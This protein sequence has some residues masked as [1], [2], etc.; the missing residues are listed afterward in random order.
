MIFQVDRF[1][2]FD[3]QLDVTIKVGVAIRF[4]PHLYVFNSG[5]LI[6]M[7]KGIV[8]IVGRYTALF[9][10]I[11]N[12]VYLRLG[13]FIHVNCL[14][15]LQPPAERLGLDMKKG[16]EIVFR[17]ISLLKVLAY[18]S[19]RNTTTAPHRMRISMPVTGIGLYLRCRCYCRKPSS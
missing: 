3:F 6:R 5:I 10:K 17:H 19:K 7:E 12:S 16:V 1:S 15:V 4:I 14:C 11:L 8:V 18:P 13:F 2:A 9:I